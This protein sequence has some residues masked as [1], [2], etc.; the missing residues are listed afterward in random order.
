MSPSP[1]PTSLPEYEDQE[2]RIQAAI[3]AVYDS[4]FKP[5]ST[6][7]YQLSF[8]KAAIDFK[9]PRPTLQNRFNGMPTRK[10]ARVKQQI[11]SPGQEDVL[12]DWAREMGR[13]GLP[14]DSTVMIDHASDIVGKPVG[15]SW[16]DGFRSRHPDLKL[17]WTTPL[18]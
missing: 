13:R 10:Q 5:G 17:K 3:K 6:T 12:A 1:S 7:V 14:I 9:V 16:L 8:R 4:G 18:V 11:L 15:R 2:T